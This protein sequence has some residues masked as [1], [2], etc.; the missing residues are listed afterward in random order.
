MS[1]CS[2]VGR[3][4]NERFWDG[5][6]ERSVAVGEVGSSILDCKFIATIVLEL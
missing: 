6:I 4:I 1:S 5:V 3:S 2:S